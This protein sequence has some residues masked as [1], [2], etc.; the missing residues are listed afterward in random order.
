MILRQTI[1]VMVYGARMDGLVVFN[2]IFSPLNL[3]ACIY[4]RM[5]ESR[6]NQDID[7]NQSCKEGLKEGR[8]EGRK[9]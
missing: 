8:K 7:T 5:M 3:Y 1:D 4:E 6:G 2:A 9:M